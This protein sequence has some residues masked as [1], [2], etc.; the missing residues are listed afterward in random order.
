MRRGRT[1]DGACERRLL[2]ELFLKA[3]QG[4]EQCSSKNE[5]PTSLPSATAARVWNIQSS[6][7]QLRHLFNHPGQDQ[8]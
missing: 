3:D 5:I 2:E 1:G 4:L 7:Y 6:S 8:C